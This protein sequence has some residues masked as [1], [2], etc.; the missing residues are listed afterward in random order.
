MVNRSEAINERML[1]LLEQ[2]GLQDRLIIENRADQPS[3]ID[4][5]RVQQKIE[6]DIIASKQYL[7][8]AI[9][10]SIKK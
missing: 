6:D 3:E 7:Q 4:Y 8:D 1:S 2:Y 5:M 10:P 9:E